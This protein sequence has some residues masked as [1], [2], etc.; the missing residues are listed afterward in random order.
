MA[1]KSAR[2]EGAGRQETGHADFDTGFG[3]GV[4]WLTVGQV[5]AGRPGPNR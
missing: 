3:L 5:Y 1:N 4:R 2:A